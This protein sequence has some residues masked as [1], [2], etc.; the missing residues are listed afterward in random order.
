MFEFVAAMPVNSVDPSGLIPPDHCDLE[1]IRIVAAICHLI[2]TL[3]R[4]RFSLP[5]LEFTRAIAKSEINIAIG[6]KPPEV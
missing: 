6:A 2:S 4:R 1:R 5:V 3:G